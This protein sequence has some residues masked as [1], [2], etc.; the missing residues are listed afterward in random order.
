M[1][2]DDVILDETAVTDISGT[3]R[4]DADDGGMFIDWLPDGIEKDAAD[5]GTDDEE[6]SDDKQENSDD[7]TDDSYSSEDTENPVETDSPGFVLGCEVRR[8]IFASG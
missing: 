3:A 2:L 1:V 6:T 7:I 5:E 4:F 8:K